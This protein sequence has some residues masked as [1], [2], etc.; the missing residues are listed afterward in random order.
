[1]GRSLFCGADARHGGTQPIHLR[2]Q[3]APARMGRKPLLTAA[4]DLGHQ[5]TPSSSE[6]DFTLS[7]FAISFRRSLRHASEASGV[8]E[9]AMRCGL[10]C[11]EEGDHEVRQLAPRAGHTGCRGEPEKIS[12]ARK[13]VI[14]L[15]FKPSAL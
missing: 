1:M 15:R 5:A 10:L 11:N 14:S 13:G 4:P 6:F 9:A 3:S 7:V 8:P 12:V 2:E